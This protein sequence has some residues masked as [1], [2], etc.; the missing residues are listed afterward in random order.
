MQPQNIIQPSQAPAVQTPPDIGTAKAPKQFLKGNK[1]QLLIG[2]LAFLI[3]ANMGISA[4]LFYRVNNYSA[5][6]AV[7]LKQTSKSSSTFNGDNTLYIDTKSKSVGVGSATPE[8]LQVASPV[9]QPT[10]G[11]ANV[12]LGLLNG[13]PT[14]LFEDK[15][16]Q[17]WQIGTSAGSLQL[18]SGETQYLKIGKDGAVAIAKDLQVQGSTTLTSNLNAGNNTLFVDAGKGVAIGGASTNGYKLYVGGNLRTTSLQADG[19]INVAA[20]SAGAPAITLSKGSNSGIFSPG[21]NIV[22]ITSNGNEVLRVQPGN[23]STLNAG[24]NV[25]GYLQAGNAA[26]RIDRFTGTL[27]GSGT[28]SVAHGIS[29]AQ[30]RVLFTMAWYQGPGGQ[31]RSLSVDYV[32]GSSFQ[33][34]G[35]T[36][37]AA[38]RGAI[39]YTADTAGW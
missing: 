23:V 16:A 15:D 27:D 32:N 37:G 18:A 33:V 1:A 24:L 35:G 6:S 10:R 8:G 36:G 21:T 14:L 39:I 25:G 9:T 17:T 4:W 19:Q 3:V 11:A 5:L 38:W 12:R 26:W 31:A 13:E 29:N 28:G 2:A 7:G 22:S 30:S 34:S 20:G